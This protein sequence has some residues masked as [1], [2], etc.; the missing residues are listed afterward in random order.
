MKK[1]YYI[2]DIHLELRNNKILTFSPENLKEDNYL[3]LCGDIGCP[4]HPN[5][6]K[7]LNVHSELYTHIFIITGN[8]EY[9]SGNKQR[10]VSETDAKITEL[11]STYSN[12]TFLTT[13]K[14]YQIGKTL[15]IGCPLWSQVDLAAES[16]MN[17]YNRIY[18]ESHI[19]H[20]TSYRK[21]S[22]FGRTKK[23]WNKAGR[24]LIS[25]TDVLSMHTE[26]LDYLTQAINYDFSNM[27]LNEDF[28]P[29]KIEKII[30]L[31]HHAPSFK[32]LDQTV[33]TEN[34]VFD[35]EDSD[36]W[37][38]PVYIP[39]VDNCYATDCEFLFRSPVICWIS[40]H[41]HECKEE[42]IKGISCVS[43]C[44]GY[45][46]QETGFVLNKSIDF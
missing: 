46:G 24:K 42:K 17:D 39:N 22:S 13:N 2:S 44:F 11:V 29:N 23:V 30:V 1:L 19:P 6:T 26:M 31:T 41:T 45:P 35:S 33:S 15:F 3:A 27:E 4:F 38:K 16:K 18:V 5:Y 14:P 34:P 32:M 8:H 9:Y 40:G 12:I 20:P 28:D 25:Y 10:T 37:D 36:D 7:F 43:N 21:P